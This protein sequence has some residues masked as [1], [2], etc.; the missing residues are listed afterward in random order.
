[1]HLKI[2]SIVCGAALMTV[3]GT[4]CAS[5]RNTAAIPASNA[6]VLEVSSAPAPAPVAVTP[7]PAPI[8]PAPVEPA[9]VV[10]ASAVG[11]RY[12]VQ[13]GDTL[14]KISTTQYGDGKQ[15]QKICSANPGLSPGTLKAGQTIVIP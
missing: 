11:S 2:A 14:W 5:K 6:S 8:A 13:K 10:T 7:A 3:V 4:G 1:M 9:P 12:T 15:W